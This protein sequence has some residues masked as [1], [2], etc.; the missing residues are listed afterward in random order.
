MKAEIICIGTEL[1]LGEIVDTN[2]AYLSKILAELGIDVYYK[3]TVGDNLDRIVDTLR[4]AWERSDLLL[5]SGGL[6]PTQDDLTREAIA[7]FLGEESV[8]HEGAM[9]EIAEYFQKAGRVMVESNR[10]QA[11]LP[12][13]AEPLT[14]RWGTAPGV[15]LAKQGKFLAA[16]PGVPLELYKL[17]EEEVIPRIKEVLGNDR[18]GLVTRTLRAVGIGESALEE[19][20]VDLIEAQSDV[21]IAP[22]AKRGEVH[23]RLAVKAA[24]REDGL[25]RIAPV[26]AALGERLANYIYGID[27]ENLETVVG[28][29]LAER[30]LTL[31]TAESCSGGLIGHRITD[32]PGSSAYYMVGIISYSNE[33]KQKLLGV[34][35][36]TLRNFGAVSAETAAEMAEGV[37]SRYGITIGLASTGIAGPG[38]GTPDKPVGLVYL[39]LATPD[40]VNVGKNLFRWDRSQNK[41]ATSQAGLAMLWQYLTGTL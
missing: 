3:S 5:L 37:R 1:L 36:E 7:C 18:L 17:M 16:M 27:Q 23:L 34:K 41:L 39:A 35:D 11:M 31:G 28:R 26:E 32:V 2:A 22:Y 25:A 8:L 20:I 30:G 33:A 10:R 38:G 15:W 4:R 13:S 14:N 29:L 21:T 12:P 9:A 6:G 40:G 19:R 24:S